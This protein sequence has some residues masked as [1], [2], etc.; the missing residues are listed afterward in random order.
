MKDWITQ[1]FAT[2]DR[3]DADGFVSFFT[4]DACFRF[5]NTPVICNKENIRDA[6][7]QFFSNIKSLRHRILTVWEQDAVVI[8]EGEVKYT[9]HNGGEL[10]VPVS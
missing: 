3:K 9:L 7:A 1:L 4:P 2:I 6:V 10:E 8:C 5:A